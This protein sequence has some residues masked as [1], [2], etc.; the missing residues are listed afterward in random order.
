MAETGR[1]LLGLGAL[2]LFLGAGLILAARLGLPLGKLPG[3]L[4]WRGR[5]TEVWAPLGTS[6]LVSIALTLVL[7]LLSRFWR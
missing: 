5:H 2:L 3:D 6:L 4:H 1:L 7:S